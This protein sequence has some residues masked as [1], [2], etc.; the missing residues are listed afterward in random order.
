M[1]S[2]FGPPMSWVH[3][4]LGDGGDAAGQ[5][6]RLVSAL[7]CALHCEVGGSIFAG[8]F[9]QPGSVAMGAFLPEVF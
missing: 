2:S 3:Y 9:E 1:V 7:G 8:N 5:G 6:A 4:I